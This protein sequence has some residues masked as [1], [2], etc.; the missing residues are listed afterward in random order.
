MLS[1]FQKYPGRRWLV[2][3][4]CPAELGGFFEKLDFSTGE[5]SQLQMSIEL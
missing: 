3:A 2:P 4:I 1:L 5:L